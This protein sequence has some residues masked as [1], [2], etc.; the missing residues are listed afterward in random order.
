MK[1]LVVGVHGFG[2]MHLSAIKDMDISIVER[3]NDVINEVTKKFDIKKVYDNYDD[4][5]KDHFDIVDLIV[6]HYLHK[7]MAI[8]A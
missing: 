8:K 5:L 6:P 3:N 2:K 4:A 7:E 1:I